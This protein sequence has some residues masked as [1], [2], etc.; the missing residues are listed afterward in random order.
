M[1]IEICGTIASGKTTLAK[2]LEG[3]GYRTIYERFQDN[4]FLNDFYQKSNAD[5]SFETELVFTLLHYNMMK[6]NQTKS[7]ILVS[8]YS[9][10]QDYCYGINN[11]KREELEQFL[12]LF[13]YIQ[14][15]L[16]EP[17]LIIYLRCSTDCLMKRIAERG[18][19][20]EQTISPEYLES[21]DQMLSSHIWIDNPDEQIMVLDSE[22][23]NFR[24]NEEDKT[25]I[26]EMIMAKLEVNQKSE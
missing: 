15:S 19:G 14:R 26:L 3:Q 1:R 20:N 22:K 18:R 9:I 23:Y 12:S 2:F 21:I 17:S 24:D 7:D 8:D 13:D 16:G 11:L 5:N 10:F 4:P 25:R 6:T